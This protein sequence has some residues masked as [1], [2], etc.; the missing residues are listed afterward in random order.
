MRAHQHLKPGDM[1][2]HQ[3]CFPGQPMVFWS[4]AK[5]NNTFFS[6]KKVCRVRF[7]F[8]R[9]KSHTLGVHSFYMFL[10]F[11]IWINLHKDSQTI[12]VLTRN[13]VKLAKSSNVYWI[14][15]LFHSYSVR[16]HRNRVVGCI[17]S[18]DL[19]RVEMCVPWYVFPHCPLRIHNALTKGQID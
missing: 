18:D 12:S 11:S 4:D 9:S 19:L 7:S 16:A 14:P 3:N 5:I 8:L 13:R 17:T 2:W 15:T 6:R 10:K 1:G